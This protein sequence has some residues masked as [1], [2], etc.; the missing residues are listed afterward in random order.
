M[1]CLATGPFVVL[2]L[3][4]EAETTQGHFPGAIAPCVGTLMWP[5]LT[6]SKNIQA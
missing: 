5:K 2:G 1:R 4:S 6:D 3:T